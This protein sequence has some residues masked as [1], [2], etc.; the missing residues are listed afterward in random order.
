MSESDRQEQGI[1][2]I[3]TCAARS[4][5]PMDIQDFVRLAQA[6]SWDVYVIATPQ[7][8]KFIDI[9][10]LERL[11]SH[12][13]RSEY[14]HPAEPDSMPKANAIV[15]APAT[16]N[17]INKWAQGITDTLALGILCEHIGLGTP[18]I[19]IPCV[20][21]ESL[22]RHPTFTKSIKLLKDCG[23]FVL[24]EPQKYSPMNNVPWKVVLEKLHEVTAK[25]S[26][27]QQKEEM[28]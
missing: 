21:S 13:I 26:L 6:V 14:R 25:C 8:T 22:A 24:Y 23:V 28:Y 17:T 18:I 7:G 2:Y 4:P 19:T 10:L 15:V 20:P 1:L 12:P 11:T 9:L 5:E 16:F 3:I 27:Q